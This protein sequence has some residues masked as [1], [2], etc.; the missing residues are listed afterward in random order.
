[1]RDLKI[2]KY[3]AYEYAIILIYISN[4]NNK[5]TLIRREIYIIDN[6]SI[7]T[8]I[9]IDIIKSKGII[10]DI[11]KNLVIINLYYSL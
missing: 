8:F 4:N 9:R 5:V 2:K 11:S 6:L 1:M 10:L 7:K 3:N